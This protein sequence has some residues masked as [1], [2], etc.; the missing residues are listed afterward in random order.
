MAATSSSS[1]ILPT[2]VPPQREI[3][4][5]GFFNFFWPHIVNTDG[6]INHNGLTRRMET[7]LGLLGPSM[8]AVYN[9]LEYCHCPHSGIITLVCCVPFPVIFAEAIE[10]R[11][12][13]VS[14]RIKELVK[15]EL[16]SS[17]APTD[18]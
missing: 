16:P 9:T 2:S 13:V 17:Q 12:A 7:V 8:A 3:P 1:S 10:Y 4:K 15:K 6:E 11:A 18:P 14:A 5:K